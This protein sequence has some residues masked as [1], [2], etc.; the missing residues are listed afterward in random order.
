MRTGNVRTAM[1]ERFRGPRGLEVGHVHGGIEQ[2]Q[3]GDPR[4]DGLAAPV[5][6]EL[7]I[8]VADVGLDG[9]RRDVQLVGELY[10]RSAAGRTAGLSPGQV[11]IL[12]SGGMPDQLS[13]REQCA[14]QFARQLTTERHI[15]QSLYDQAAE[16]L[17]TR[18]IVDMLHLIGAYQFVCTLLNTFDIPAPEGT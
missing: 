6:A 16:L 8:E 14:W 9:V 5:H 12:A 11:D 4:G 13:A 1:P 10:S 3:R 17:G 15:G 7:F 2:G 18:G